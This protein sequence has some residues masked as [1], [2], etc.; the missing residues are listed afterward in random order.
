MNHTEEKCANTIVAI[1]SST[2]GPKALQKV[3]K[4]LPKDYPYPVVVVQHMPTGFTK[5][6][7]SRLNDLCQMSVKEGEEGE[8]LKPGVVYIAKSG[9]HLTVRKTMAGKHVLQYLDA[10][11]RQGV[12]PCANYLFESLA[13]CKFERHICVVLTGMGSDGTDGIQTL[14]KKKKCYVISQDEDTSAI[15]GM[16]KRV[17]E[18]GLSD[19]VLPLNKISQEIIKLRG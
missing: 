7:A 12:K 19:I 16:P 2:G 18:A 11:N 10:P 15:Y 5:V 9:M 17:F 1:A 6:M 8:C 14:K 13:D 4:D 3:L